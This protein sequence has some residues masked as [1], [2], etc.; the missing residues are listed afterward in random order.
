MKLY[1]EAAQCIGIYHVSMAVNRSSAL[2]T[3]GKESCNTDRDSISPNHPFFSLKKGD[4]MEL[5][6]AFVKRESATNVIY[7]SQPDDE[8]PLPQWKGKHAIKVNHIYS[9]VVTKISQTACTLS[10]GPSVFTNMA[11]VDASSSAKVIRHFK[12]NCFVGQ[13]VVIA[14]EEI[15]KKSQRLHQMNVTRAGIES[16]ISSDDSKLNDLGTV[17]ISN[18]VNFKKGRKVWGE[19]LW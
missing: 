10:L 11:Y 16:Y 2:D 18:S 4:Q 6:V 5:K 19:C 1:S 9:S 3:V 17:Q 8:T 15:S 13:K 14:V 7:L 12:K